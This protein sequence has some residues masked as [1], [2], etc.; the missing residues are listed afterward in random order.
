[1]RKRDRAHAQAYAAVALVCLT[2]LFVVLVIT[3][4]TQS[5]LSIRCEQQLAFLIKYEAGEQIA[6]PLVGTPPECRAK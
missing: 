6:Y 2:L 4:N 1:M 5:T 3:M